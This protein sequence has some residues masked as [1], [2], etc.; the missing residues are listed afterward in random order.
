[1]VEIATG[2]TLLG[3]L[4]FVVPVLWGGLILIA[5]A[6]VALEKLG[7]VLRSRRA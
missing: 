4:M 1:M 6:G 3:W 2:L 7:A 5:L